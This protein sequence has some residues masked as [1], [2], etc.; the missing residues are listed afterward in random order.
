[1]GNMDSWDVTL[2][3]VAAYLAITAL[4]RL[5]ARRRNHLIEQ[6]QRQA[7]EGQSGQQGRDNAQGR[8]RQSA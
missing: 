5:I 4:V 6:L 7:E 8:R 3:V 1:M 2:L